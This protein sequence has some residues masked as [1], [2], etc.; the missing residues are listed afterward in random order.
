MRRKLLVFSIV[1]ILLLANSGITVAGGPPAE[2]VELEPSYYDGDVYLLAIPSAI[3]HNSNQAT[4]ACFNLGPDLTDQQTGPYLT[5]Y[6][7]LA[8][9]ATQVAC[10]DGTLRHD[11]VLSGIPGTEGY[12]P[13]WRIVLATPG[14]A[15]HAG[16]M[17]R[18]SAEDVGAAV[19]VGELV[20]TDTGVVFDAPV[21][22]QAG[23]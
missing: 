16:T 22:G 13:R 15:F 9:G 4:F 3:S 8:P 19:A 12:V 21:L 18:T 11:H 10:P 20:L 5:L 6:V 17:P 14:P 7:I 2:Q 23:R 1:S